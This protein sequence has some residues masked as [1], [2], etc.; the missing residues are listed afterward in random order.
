MSTTISAPERVGP[1]VGADVPDAATRPK[2][3]RRRASRAPYYLIVPAII[4]LLVGTGYPLV[5]QVVTSF[6]EYGLAQQFGKP[7]PFVGLHNYIAL[8]TGTG[9]W[10]IVLRS[11]AFCVVTAVVTMILGIALALVMRNVARVPRIV[12]QVSLLLAWAMP[13]VAQMTVWSWLVDDRNGILNYVLSRVPG[14][15]LVGHNWLVNPWS[16]FLVASVIITWASVP[17]VAFSVYASFTTVG[18]EVLEAASID[19]ASRGQVLRQI[20][21]PII[22]PVLAIVLLLQLIW[23]L[24]V[25]SQIKL[26]QDRGSFGSKYDLLGTYIYK[27]G[28]GSQDF[29]TA[30]AAAIIVMILTLGLSWVYIRQLLKEDAQS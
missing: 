18:E 29:G 5:W 24:R 25:F 28:T 6:R 19:G 14:I 23:D 21:L 15:D 11:I 10:T 8:V 27:L 3:R 7:A 9:F 1:P 22:R 16:F 20:I 26:L 4:A 30:S 12:L 13:I 2:R 17:F